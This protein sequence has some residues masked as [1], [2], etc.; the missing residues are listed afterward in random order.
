MSF[1]RVCPFCH[2]AFT[3]RY[4]QAKYCSISCSNKASTLST[5]DELRSYLLARVTIPE[6]KNAC[7]LW[8][9][10]FDSHGYGM[11]FVKNA[12]IRAH[13]VSHELFIG[14][15]PEGM[16][17]L[18][19]C[20]NPPCI[21]PHHLRYGTKRENAHDRT[22]HGRQVR[23]SQHT[24]TRLTEKDVEDILESFHLRNE[25]Q[26]D[27]ALRYNVNFVTIHDIVQRKSWNHVHKGL[28]PPPEKDGRTVVTA[29][30]VR[31]MRK[32]YQEGTSAGVLAKRFHLDVTQ[33]WRICTYRSWKQ[34]T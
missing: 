26:K 32:L 31:L 6:D 34:I 10:S 29:D 17:I 3:T 33:T 8:Q 28:F 18:H 14:P 16:Y 1:E 21:S 13:R 20:D 24:R 25:T 30:D 15:I 7:W 19:A 23:G 22:V 11:M 9:G 27:L 4:R 12:S 5:P 2:Q